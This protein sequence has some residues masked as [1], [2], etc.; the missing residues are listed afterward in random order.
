M[1]CTAVLLL[2]LPVLLVAS[3][4]DGGGEKPLSKNGA[5]CARTNREMTVDGIEFVEIGPGSFLMGSDSNWGMYAVPEDEKPVHR[6]T[7]ASAFWIAKHEITNQLYER[8]APS[9]ERAS[10]R[11]DTM[12]VD[13][14]SWEAA[15]KYCLW[16]GGRSGLPIRLPSEAEWEAACRAGSQSAFCFGDDEAE[17]SKFAWF[18]WSRGGPSTVGLKSPNAWGLFDMHGN[19]WEWCADTWHPNYEGAPTDGSAWIDAASPDRVRRGGGW[20][21]S[22]ALSLRSSS[23]A[24][25]SPEPDPQISVQGFR[26][27]MGP[28][29]E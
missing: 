26:P 2:A 17:L 19:V 5:P 16:L 13:N 4:S 18:D 21:P 8:F 20:F 10:S 14:V 24:S 22:W 11:W 27:A 23:R 6:V 9:H 29:E 25:R 3:C 1:K 12:P 15:A 7:F 28:L